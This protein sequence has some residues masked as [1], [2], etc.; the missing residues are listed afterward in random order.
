MEPDEV[1][2][3]SWNAEKQTLSTQPTARRV[4]LDCGNDSCEANAHKQPLIVGLGAAALP[5]GITSE[6]RFAWRSGLLR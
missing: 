5:A 6:Q 1:L 4:R 2:E 3:H